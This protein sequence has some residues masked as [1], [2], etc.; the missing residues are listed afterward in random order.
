VRDLLVSVLAAA[1]ITALGLA[2]LSAVTLAPWLVAL[3][4]ADTRR[5]SAAGWGAA[6]LAGSAAALA[7]ATGLLLVGAPVVLVSLAAVV[8]AW[9]VPV[10]LWRAGPGARPLGA[11]Q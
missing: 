3:Q 1:V 7:V 6:A 4:A 5:R 10:G 9:A 8:L 2:A 11:H